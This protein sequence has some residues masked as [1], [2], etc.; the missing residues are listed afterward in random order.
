MKCPGCGADYSARLA[1]CPYCGTVNESAVRREKDKE[2]RRKL[3][4]SLRIRTAREAGP[5]ITI[6]VLNRIAAALLAL[7]LIVF[8][9][10][11]LVFY[12]GERRAAADVE[13]LSQEQNVA[14]LESLKAEGDYAGI[15]EYLSDHE[16]S[17]YEEGIEEYWQLYEIYEDMRGFWEAADETEGL[18]SEEAASDTWRYEALA[19]SVLDI[20]QY[21]SSEYESERVLEGNEELYSQWRD[22]TGLYLRTRFGMTEA[23]LSQWLEV[24]DADYEQ[25]EQLGQFLKERAAEY[26]SQ[27]EF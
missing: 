16:L 8:A 13:V 24:P 21:G 9:A 27:T 19:R 3:L 1:Q 6:Q 4:R 12:I 25:E 11:F 26:G 23:E 10:V 20:W 22:E 18:S 14:N 5:R 7:W 17:M 15:A 2:E